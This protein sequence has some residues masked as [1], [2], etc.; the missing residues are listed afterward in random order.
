MP[1]RKERGQL[2]LFV[3]GSLRDLLPDDHVLVR[4]DG[5]LDPSWLRD[6]VAGLYCPNNGRPGVDPEGAVRPMFARFLHG[7][8][9]DRRLMREAQV[10]LAIR[11]FIGYGLHEALPDHS[12]LTRI[13]R[14]RPAPKR[15]A[16]IALRR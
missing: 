1:G 8:V 15:G 10:N 6:E 3:T 4:V 13:G 2:E 5:V 7:I 12:F 9:H 11:W 14:S 16:S